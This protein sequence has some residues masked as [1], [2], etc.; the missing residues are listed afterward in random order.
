M[1]GSC[2]VIS[3]L[4]QC[5]SVH[6][7][8]AAFFFPTLTVFFCFTSPLWSMQP[9]GFHTLLLHSLLLDSSSHMKVV[10]CCSLC[11]S[12]ALHC[13]ALHCIALHSVAF[14]VTFFFSHKEHHHAKETPMIPALFLSSLALLV[15]ISFAWM[16]WLWTRMPF[17]GS[18]SATLSIF[19]SIILFECNL[20]AV[21]STWFWFKHASMHCMGTHTHTRPC[22]RVASQRVCAGLCCCHCCSIWFLT[23]KWMV[24]LTEHFG[25]SDLISSQLC[26]QKHT[27]FSLVIYSFRE[28]ISEL[29]PCFWWMRFSHLSDVSSRIEIYFWLHYITWVHSCTYLGAFY[30]NDNTPLSYSLEDKRKCFFSI[31]VLNWLHICFDFQHWYDTAMRVTK[32]HFMKRCFR[33]G[34]PDCLNSEWWIGSFWRQRFVFGWTGA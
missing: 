30:N 25:V 9:S 24:K 27:S 10:P 26:C 14:F 6:L 12:R 3:L 8:V 18:S 17:G 29:C 34:A 22:L 32:L 33:S 4:L 20:Q 21:P 5:S 13:I 28:I 11:S 16:H 19:L 1:M 15:N 31:R 2:L 7:T 23:L